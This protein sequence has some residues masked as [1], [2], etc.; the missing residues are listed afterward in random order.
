MQFSQGKKPALSRVSLDIRPLKDERKEYIYIYETFSS[1]P[2]SLII[3]ERNCEKCDEKFLKF[4]IISRGY[5]LITLRSNFYDI[6][7]LLVIRNLF[8]P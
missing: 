6:V 3:R 5:L 1:P 7:L 8:C 2:C 4:I